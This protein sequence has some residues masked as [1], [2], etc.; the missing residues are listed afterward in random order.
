MFMVPYLNELNIG[1][2]IVAQ[3]VYTGVFDAVTNMLAI[4]ENYSRKYCTEF[5]L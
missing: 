4:L 5:S 3:S 2:A 1:H